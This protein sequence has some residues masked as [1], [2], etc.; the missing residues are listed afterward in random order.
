[1]FIRLCG[2]IYFIKDRGINI[3][4]TF[5]KKNRYRYP[6]NFSNETKFLDWNMSCVVLEE[7]NEYIEELICLATLV[8]YINKLKDEFLSCPLYEY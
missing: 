8:M 7:I 2:C 5:G 1:M 4:Y 3:S 6:K